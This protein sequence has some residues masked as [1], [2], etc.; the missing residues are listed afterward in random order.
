MINVAENET[1]LW[2]AFQQGDRESFAKIYHQYFHN[3]FEYGSRI[4]EDRELVKDCIHDL[5]IKLWSNK[6]NLGKVENIKAYLLV[7]LRGTI[8]NRIQKNSKHRSMEIKDDQ[9]FELTFSVE[10]ELIRREQ[11]NADA[12]ELLKSI[13]QLTTRQKEFIYLRYFED[14]NYDEISSV[15]SISTKA[16]YK[17]SA[18]SL[19]GLR[20][21]Y[22]LSKPAFLVF[23][24][25][26]TSDLYNQAYCFIFIQ[27]ARFTFFIFF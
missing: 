8:Y 6:S 27:G 18:R 11:L 20:E 24:S 23:L 7:S 4:N 17:L 15:M 13:N 2:Q 12:K 22:T 21:I 25:L 16:T 5:F 19:E 26:I 10:N 14:M 9:N 3:L 1:H